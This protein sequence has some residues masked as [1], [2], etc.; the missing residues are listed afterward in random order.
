MVFEGCFS[1]ALANGTASVSGSG[2]VPVLVGSDPYLIRSLVPGNGITITPAGDEIIIARSGG[3][4]GSGDLQDAYIAGNSIMVDN[5]LPLT[6]ES[7]ASSSGFIARR[8]YSFPPATYTDG[9]TLL[10]LPAPTE[11]IAYLE[12]IFLGYSGALD[13]MV[14]LGIKISPYSYSVH[15]HN[16]SAQLPSAPIIPVRTGSNLAFILATGDSLTYTIASTVIRTS[17]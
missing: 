4:S 17:L 9:D 3:G 1:G 2:G 8:E 10:T 13:L 14:R 15:V 11:R 5:S 16:S 6:V 12:V 7:M